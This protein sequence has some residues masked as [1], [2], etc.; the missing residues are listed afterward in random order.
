MTFGLR[1]AVAQRRGITL[2]L[3]PAFSSCFL[4]IDSSLPMIDP[5]GVKVT[6][7]RGATRSRIHAVI[8]DLIRLKC[9]YV[10]IDAPCSRPFVRSPS[11]MTLFS[12]FIYPLQYDCE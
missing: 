11:L 9:F 10:K 8:L 5:A 12:Y 2:S 3:R 4:R 6:P 1:C 7:G